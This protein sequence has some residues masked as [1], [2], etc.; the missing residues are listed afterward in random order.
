[1]K[2]LETLQKKVEELGPLKR[3]WFT[4]F[5]LDIPFFET[6]VL[7]VLLREEKPQT[8][9]DFE[10]MQMQ[11]A[12][13]LQQANIKNAST[14]YLDVRIF[15]DLKMLESGQ[16][17]R[18]AIPIHGILPKW[19]KNFDNESLFH[20]KVILLE[21]TNGE[22]VLGAGSA[23]LTLSGWARNQEVFIFRTVTSKN[24]YTQIVSFFSPLLKSV[25]INQEKKLGKGLS[26]VDETPSWQFIH[27]FQEINFLGELFKDISP[28]KLTIWSPYFS[29]ELADLLN[30]ITKYYGSKDLNFSIVPDLILNNQV[31]TIWTEELQILLNSG[32]LKFHHHPT[33]R[34]ENTLMTHAK[35]WLATGKKS[36]LAVGSWNCTKHGCASFTDRNIE[37]GILIE[38]P[39][40]TAI[41]GSDININKA[42]FITPQE[43]EKERLNVDDY[44]LPF[45]IQVC[46]DWESRSYKVQVKK[47]EHC[48]LN[49]YQLKLP[50]LT[51]LITLK[52]VKNLEGDLHSFVTNNYVV[53][54]NPALLADHCFE[55]LH[56]NKL[57]FR[58]LIYETNIGNRPAFSYDSIYD[59]FNDLIKNVSP[60]ESTKL[61]LHSTLR[62]TE[63]TDETFETSSNVVLNEI[64]YFRLFRA[65]DQFNKRLTET[66]NLESLEKLL[67]VL[68]GNLQE[69]V[70]KVDEHIINF[71]QNTVFN[72][73]LWQEVK[74]LEKLSRIT[75]NTLTSKTQL[76]EDKWKTL[77]LQASEVKLPEAIKG[78]TGYMKSIKKMCH[79]EK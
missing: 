6:H 61:R 17:K 2:L 14:N 52:W 39:N 8:R 5:N 31:R 15:C 57:E 12:P 9:I 46:F 18:T 68:P 30:V 65:F 56:D 67:F 41:A 25:G 10:N 35:L 47:N 13:T 24:Q 34:S 58:G 75:F 26:F 74:S 51:S 62:Q 16:L 29:P 69:L 71:N 73:F 37:A 63:L 36:R 66:K 50:G 45:E 7:P 60:I 77:T 28:K 78:N 44:P 23:N 53:A 22:M 76:N 4:T 38:V 55:V 72:W 21:G 3:A 49:R 54:N 70:Q 1:M 43:L 59:L 42:N 48:A 64:S 19:L 20:P 40:N 33:S 11:L 27:S 32:R 79:Y